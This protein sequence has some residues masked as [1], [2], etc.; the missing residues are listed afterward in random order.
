MADPAGF[1]ELFRAEYP[2]VLRVVEAILGERGRSEELTQDAFAEAYARWRRVGG[3]D[4]PGAWVRRVAIRRAVRERSRA[5]VA[6]SP[7]ADEPSSEQH[8]D[9]GRALAALP[10]RQRAAVALHYLV[11][12]PVA[13]V[14]QAMG[15]APATVKVHLHRARA[16]LAELLDAPEPTR[17]DA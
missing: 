13:E 12:L 15:C 7:P 11:D 8:L 14:A 2:P 10:T 3:Y 5:V 16:R 4:R 6:L 1:E 9:I 17:R